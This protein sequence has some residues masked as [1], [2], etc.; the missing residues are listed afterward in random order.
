MEGNLSSRL[1]TVFL[2]GVLPLAAQTS[3]LQ[4][5]VTDAQAAA[6]PEAVV[7]AINL[8]TSAARKA[9]TAA[10]GAYSFLQVQPGK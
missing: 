4:G 3:S 6:I 10:T 8:S 5:V 9:V 1:L 2:L 7:T